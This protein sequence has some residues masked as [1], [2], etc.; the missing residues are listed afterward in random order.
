MILLCAGKDPELLPM[1][2]LCMEGNVTFTAIRA[3]KLFRTVLTCRTLLQVQ[4][5][6]IIHITLNTSS[7]ALNSHISCCVVRTYFF[8]FLLHGAN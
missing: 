1:R 6:K 2:A 7:C 5:A 4:Y 3:D 8:Y